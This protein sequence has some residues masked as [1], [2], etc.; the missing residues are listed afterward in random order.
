MFLNKAEKIW[1][2]SLNSGIDREVDIEIEDVEITEKKEIGE[3]TPELDE[4]VFK[5]REDDFA[6]AEC[7]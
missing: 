5:D 2:L 4:D 6:F 1:N 7:F 3:K